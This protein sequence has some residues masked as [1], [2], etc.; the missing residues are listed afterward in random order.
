MLAALGTLASVAIPK[1]MTFVSKKLSN[2]RV[3]HAAAKIIKHADMI[4]RKVHHISQHPA[5]K[6]AR[7]ILVDEYKKP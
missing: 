7:K 4:G 1:I 2:H 6:Q 3:G 5:M